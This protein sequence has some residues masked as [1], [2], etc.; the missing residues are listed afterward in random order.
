MLSFVQSQ[1]WSKGSFQVRVYCQINL[2]MSIILVKKKVF[3]AFLSM[4]RT[5]YPISHTHTLRE[6]VLVSP[7]HFD[8]KYHLNVQC[9]FMKPIIFLDL[10]LIKQSKNKTNKQPKKNKKTPLQY[11]HVA[12]KAGLTNAICQRARI[13]LRHWNKIT[14]S[15]T[16]IYLMFTLESRHG[17]YWMVQWPCFGLWA[18]SWWLLP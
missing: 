7:E 17:P 12:T 4:S 6:R 13:F 16:I 9:V 11:T 3:K 15:S 14:F 2:L 10:K 5:G 1:I 8:F 18:T